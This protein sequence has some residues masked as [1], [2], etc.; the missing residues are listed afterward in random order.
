MFLSFGLSV[1]FDSATPWTTACQDSLSITNSR[2]LPKLMSIE[3]V[4]P[5]NYLILCHLL[6]FLPSIFPIIRVFSNEISFSHQVH[7]KMRLS[8][9]AFMWFYKEIRYINPKGTQ[10]WI[11]IGRTIAEA[12]ILWSPNVKSWLIG[13]DP[14]AGKD[15]WQKE[16]GVAEDEMVG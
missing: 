9:T 8:Q 13:K 7:H 5:S 4:M 6:L 10:P 12:P 11:F 3:S 2:S 16:K 15:W 14:D 1:M